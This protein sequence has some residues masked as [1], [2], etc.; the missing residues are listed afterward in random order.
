M[1][2]KIK[3]D[4]EDAIVITHRRSCQAARRNI[5]RH[6]PPMIDEWRLLQVNLADDL[7][8]HV[9]RGE[10]VLPL[11]KDQGWPGVVDHLCGLQWNHYHTPLR[12]C[13]LQ[14]AYVFARTDWFGE[15]SFTQ[16][17]KETNVSRKGAERSAGIQGSSNLVLMF[18]LRA[19][20][21]A[22]IRR[23]VSS[24]RKQAFS[25]R[26]VGASRHDNDKVEG[27]TIDHNRI[28]LGLG[29][30]TFEHAVAAL[31][32]WKHFDLGWA[33]IV[34]PETPLETGADV[35]VLARTLG[36]WSLNACRIV[37][38]IDEDGPELKRFGFAYGT[39]QDHAERGEERFTIE[40]QANDD[41]V[42]YD[43]RAFSRPNLLAKLG[44][45]LTRS[46]QKKFARDS[47]ATM[48]ARIAVSERRAV[49]TR[50]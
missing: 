24:Q 27:Y 44:Y 28:K 25:Y 35:A 15:F 33:R 30:A 31:R 50:S 32:T 38:V 29:Q 41:S 46:Y 17:R 10:G 6:V 26:E 7:R 9:Q 8:P 43:I 5:K 42:W 22:Q 23:F 19:P 34:P 1:I 2:D 48:F 39:L 45:P 40:W 14:L 49:A 12:L 11:F 16:R 36:F 4:L 21:D 18:F 20:S 37:Y 47:L 3:F 13:A